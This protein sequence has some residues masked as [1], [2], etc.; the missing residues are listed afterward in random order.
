MSNTAE[1]GAGTGGGDCQGKC[2][3]DSWR[4]KTCRRNGC[5]WGCGANFPERFLMGK[6]LTGIPWGG[7][8]QQELYGFCLGRNFPDGN[9]SWGNVC[10]KYREGLPGMV[11]KSWCRTTSLYMQQLWFV[12]RRLTHAHTH[13]TCRHTHT[14]T[15][16]NKYNIQL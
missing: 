4:W 6:C 7:N 8:V 3:E 1:Q 10:R 13:T 2:L 15:H 5:R 14:G 9:Y 11:S 12:P 16:T